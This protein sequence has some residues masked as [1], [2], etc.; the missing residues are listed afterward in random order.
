MTFKS[1]AN[2]NN[3]GAENDEAT[4]CPGSAE[5]LSTTPSIGETKVLFTRSDSVN[6]N[7]ACALSTLAKACSKF[8]SALAKLTRALSITCCDGCLPALAF[9]RS[10]ERRV[11]KECRSRWWRYQ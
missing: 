7:C 4:V 3:T 6:S 10:E 2:K 11:G 9:H 5:R 8:T 1:R